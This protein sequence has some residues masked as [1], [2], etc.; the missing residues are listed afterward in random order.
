[1][2]AGD[3]MIASLPHAVEIITA[4]LTAAFDNTLG[5]VG[6]R[7]IG[8]GGLR[9]ITRRRK[10]LASSRHQEWRGSGQSPDLLHSRPV[11][12]RRVYLHL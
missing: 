1:M 8:Q 9:L 7:R 5:D 4:C 6:N 2:S 12:V 3:A 10:Q 11:Q